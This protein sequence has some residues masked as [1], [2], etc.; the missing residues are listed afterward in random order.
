MKFSKEIKAALIAL[1]AIIVLI[2]G[3]NFLKG[4]SFFGGDDVYTAYFPNSGQLMVSSNVTL[5]GV[6]IGKVLS[7]Q[8]NPNGDSLHKVKMTFNIH[9][10]DIRLPKGTF[11]EIG[12]L[13]FFTKALVIQLPTAGNGSFYKVGATIP[14]R[15]SVDMVTQVK[16]YADP[17]SQKLQ[18]MMLS[19]DKMVTSL[20][21]FWDTTA[22]SELEGSLKQVKLTIK[23][24]GNVADEL[25]GFVASE[26]A[27]FSKIMANVEGITL[28]LRK[29][30]DEITAIVGNTRKITDELVTADF[31]G[32]ILE[33]QTTLKKVNMVLSEVE[34][35]QGTLGKLIHDDKLY[36]EL[37]AT[38]ND[39][40]SLVTDLQ[41][42][43]ERYV[44][45]SVIGGKTKGL[46]LTKKNEDKLLKM[47]DSLPE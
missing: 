24:L 32:T 29:S 42:H 21:S 39:L 45:L 12:S 22:T 3:I 40:Q 27:Q 30:N 47:L 8:S 43:P 7:I 20:S 15:V 17:I 34:K 33:A 23:K 2:A 37:V 9:N 16:A 13:D 18:T 6:E 41:A 36:A 38:N 19:V 4:N 11:V 31:K 25:Q 10:S 28:N 26:R 35:G 14:G 46:Q 44:H 1:V 5:D